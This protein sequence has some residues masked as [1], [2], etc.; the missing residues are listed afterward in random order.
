VFQIFE[1]ANVITQASHPKKPLEPQA[2]SPA[3]GGIKVK[4]FFG[5]FLS[6]FAFWRNRTA[7]KYREAIKLKIK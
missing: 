1:M 7:P 2:K 5:A 4:Y 3:D 6:A